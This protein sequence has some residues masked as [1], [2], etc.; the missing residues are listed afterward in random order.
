MVAGMGR[1][2]RRA[3]LVCWLAGLLCTSAAG[4]EEVLI[5]VAGSS[6]V[7]PIVAQAAKLFQELHPGTRIVIGGG[8]SAHGIRAVAGDEVQVGMSS[9]ALKESE[10]R[11]W[12]DV[13]PITIGL[14]GIAIIVHARN[15]L[16]H[17]TTPQVHDLFV[18]KVGNWRQ[19]GGPD[20]AVVLVTTNERHGTFEAF[21][22]HFELEARAE[23]QQGQ[24]KRIYFRP[25]GEEEFSNPGALAVDG[26]GPALAAVMTKPH[27]LSYASLGAA[28][29]V[30]SQGAPIGMLVLD[31]VTPTERAV[32]NGTYRPQR[33][34]RVITRGEPPGRLAQ[35][36]KYLGAPEGQKIVRE[37]DCLP[38]AEE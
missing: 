7:Q 10:K 24:D 37:L 29:R 33:S 28:L 36:L 15:P 5:S 19:L 22:E 9:R 14:D 26:N 8:G 3:T 23:G 25:K 16:R 17:I 34:L 6:T 27:A 2:L 31:G 18:G 13:R 11:Q 21:N 38:A 35:F 32:R 20:A 1:S 30:I 4:E 12:P